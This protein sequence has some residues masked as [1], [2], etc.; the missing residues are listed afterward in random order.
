[1]PKP[2]LCVIILLIQ[3][4]NLAVF[5][6][7]LPEAKLLEKSPCLKVNCLICRLET[8]PYF[9]FFSHPFSN[10]LSSKRAHFGSQPCCLVQFQS[11][12]MI[13]NMSEFSTC[14]LK[15]TLINSVFQLTSGRPDQL[16]LL[17]ESNFT[18]HST[19]EE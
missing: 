12:L 15:Y 18:L 11:W 5:M 7:H 3:S 13:I 19:K 9:S 2:Q 14:M 4:P 16:D 8:E 1:M 6:L 17:S 10:N